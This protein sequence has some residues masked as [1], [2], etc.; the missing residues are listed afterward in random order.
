MFKQLTSRFN[1]KTLQPLLGRWATINPESKKDYTK[2]INF[3]I[4][5][6]NHDHCGSELCN[7]GQTKNKTKSK[8]KNKV[9]QKYGILNEEDMLPYIL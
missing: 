7:K 4:D 2:S 9:L 5:S 6:S 8:I 1:S 3:N